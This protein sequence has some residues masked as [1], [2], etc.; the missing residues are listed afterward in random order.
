MYACEELRMVGSHFPMDEGKAYQFYA[1]AL[2]HFLFALVAWAG[3][4]WGMHGGD[5]II[6][7]MDIP[8]I[9]IPDDAT[10]DLNKVLV[11]S[12]DLDLSLLPSGFLFTKRVRLPKQSK[13]EFLSVPLSGSG[14]EA[15]ILRLERAGYYKLELRVSKYM[16]NGKGAVPEEYSSSFDGYD[17]SAIISYYYR[18][19]M[20]ST[21]Q[22]KNG[23]PTFLPDNYKEWSRALFANIRQKLEH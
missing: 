12:N 16:Q 23:D 9:D 3:Q 11:N 6:S 14:P 4:G 5:K 7:Q 20:Q 22:R 17:T 2:Q 19:E 1:T 13:A 10:Y 8:P 15:F 21:V 18:I